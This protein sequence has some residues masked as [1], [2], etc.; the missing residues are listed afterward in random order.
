[1][2]TLNTRMTEKQEEAGNIFSSAVIDHATRPRN[3]GSMNDADA[4]TSVLGPCGDSMEM[5]LKARDGMVQAVTFWT[6]GCGATIACGS[7]AT[8]MAKGK[9]LEE[10]M[11]ITPQSVANELEGLPKQ[12]FHCSNLGAQALHKAIEDYRKKKADGGSHGN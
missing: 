3:A 8:E 1:M 11:K 10:A 5:W 2:E 6:D 4:Y 7:L 12:K 9:T